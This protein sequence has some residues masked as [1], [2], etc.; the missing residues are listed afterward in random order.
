MSY[1]IPLTVALCGIVAIVAGNARYELR[2]RRNR[3]RGSWLAGPLTHTWLER[4]K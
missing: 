2:R 4:A 1:G 3:K